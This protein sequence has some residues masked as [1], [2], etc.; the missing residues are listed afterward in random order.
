MSFRV[1]VFNQFNEPIKEIGAATDVDIEDGVLTIEWGSNRERATVYAP[2]SWHH[3]ET[4]E[5]D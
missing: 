1:E 3:F 5:H 2:G 4:Y